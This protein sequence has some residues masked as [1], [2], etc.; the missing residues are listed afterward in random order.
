MDARQTI[1]VGDG[2]E[3]CL[4]L[5]AFHVSFDAGLADGMA[6]V[7]AN[8]FNF[9][10]R[11]SFAQP[12]SRITKADMNAARKIRGGI[13]AG[14]RNRN[15]PVAHSVDDGAMLDFGA[16][17][18]L[19]VFRFG[20]SCKPRRISAAAM[21]DLAMKIS[22]GFNHGAGRI[23]TLGLDVPDRVSDTDLRIETKA[24]PAAD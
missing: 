14:G 7:G 23:V 2:G 21:D 4:V 1:G 12:G 9:E 22:Q 20:S 3:M 5:R 10:G 18:E 15:S 11:V 16:H 13:A 19:L 6:I 24:H 17:A 8:D